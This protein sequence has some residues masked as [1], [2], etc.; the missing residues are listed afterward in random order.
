MKQA[1]KAATLG[2]AILAASAS[3]SGMALDKGWY[4]GGNV[5]QS[6]ATIDDDGIV[7]NLAAGGLAT[8]SMKEDDTDI[9]FKLFGAY[10]FNENFAV[11]AGYFDLGQFGYM[12][13]TAPPGTLSGELELKGFNVDAVGYWLFSEKL[14]GFGR[15]GLNYADVQDKF[16]GA[17]AV[18]V[19]QPSPDEQG[20]N[21][22]IGLGLEYDFNESL[23]ARIEAERY[24]ID[25]AVG[26]MSDIDLYS[27]GL[28]FRFGGDKHEDEAAAEETETYY[29]EERPVA[30]QAEP[31]L[32]VVPVAGKA[33]EYCSILDLTFEIDNDEIQGDDKERLAVVG[34]FMTKYPETTAVIEGHSDNVGTPRHNLDLSQM[35]AEN[36]ANYLSSAFGIASTRLSAVGYGDTSPL[37][38]NRTPEGKRANRR[39]DAVI[40]CA[41]DIEGLPVVAARTTLAMEM[42][43]DE[44]KADIK[45]EYAGQLRKVAT[46]L[47]ANPKI[48]ATVE[49]HTGGLRGTPEQVMEIAQRRAQNVVDYLV[50]QQ[51]VP[52][53]QLTAQG[54]GKT[55]RFAYNTTAEG[56]REN[57]RVNIIFNYAK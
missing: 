9:G 57:R 1:K 18:T 2:L 22:K 28:V 50:Q 20:A 55:R 43:F 29:A 8:T 5:G 21:Y 41:T 51:A 39:V 35:R 15:L 19:L 47:K 31:A 12:A 46:F 53:S 16:Q 6:M 33:G 4:L 44:N 54:F 37:A 52:A 26:N 32:V 13:S 25:D 11:E 40:A 30:R 10:Q 38:D 7:A 17:G 42:Q 56:R 34:R 23:G 36:V 14:S 24:R 48:K 27:L 49:G 45:P 3:P